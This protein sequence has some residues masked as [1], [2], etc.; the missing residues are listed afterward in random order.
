LPYQLSLTIL[1]PTI[2]HGERFYD[3]SDTRYGL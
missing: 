3:H 1:L 2:D